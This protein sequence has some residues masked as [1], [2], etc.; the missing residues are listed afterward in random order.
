VG[1]KANPTG[2]LPPEPAVSGAFIAPTRSPWTP[3]HHSQAGLRLKQSRELDLPV[4][5]IAGDACNCPRT[6][7]TRRRKFIADYRARYSQPPASIWTLMA[8]EA[9]NVIRYAL[10]QTGATDPKIR[11]EYLHT[12]ARRPQD[13]K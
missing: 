13:R 3:F 9:F 6:S 11:A 12:S 7:T 1:I 2:T 10:E 8:G 5:W 4:R